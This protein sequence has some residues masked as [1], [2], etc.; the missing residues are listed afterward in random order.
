MNDKTRNLAVGLLGA[1]VGAVLGHLAFSMALQQGFYALML[2]GGFIGLGGGLLVKDRSVLRATICGV[3]GV[4]V[5]LYS[6]WR[7][8]PFA[9]DHSLGYF[10]THVHELRGLTLLMLAGGTA[11]AVWLSLGKNKT[12]PGTPVM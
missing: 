2:P 10:I 3:F 4:C 7:H 11:F 6:E 9:A 8:F 12:Q 1:A 5:G